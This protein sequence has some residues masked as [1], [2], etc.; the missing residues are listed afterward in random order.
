[1]QA[2]AKARWPAASHRTEGLAG[3]LHALDPQRVLER[4]YAWLSDPQGRPLT[5]VSQV[6]E[7]DE[8]A[9]VLADGVLQMRVTQRPPKLAGKRPGRAKP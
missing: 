1:M 3:R 7:G 6:G 4:G 5:S 9:G 2:A 8:V